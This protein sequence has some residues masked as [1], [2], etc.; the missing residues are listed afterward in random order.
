MKVYV[1][2]LDDVFDT[3]LATVLDAFTTA[4]E[5]AEMSGLTLRFDIRI[6]GVRKTVRTSQGLD[7]PIILANDSPVPDWVVVPA[8]GF[9]MPGPLQAALARPDVSEAGEVLRQWAGLGAVT[10]AACITRTFDGVPPLYID[11]GS[12]GFA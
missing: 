9:K 2:A 8:I 11:C 3:G 6:V 10:A 4:N 7:V 5:L 1:L 12:V